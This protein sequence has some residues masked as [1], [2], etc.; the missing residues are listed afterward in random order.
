M[1]VQLP[2]HADVVVVGVGTAGAV[3]AGRLAER[4][5]RDVL[6]LEAGP[7]YGP[8]QRAHWPTELLDAR[9]L[10]ETHD[11][12]YSGGNAIGDP[13]DVLT[14][15]GRRRMLVSQWLFAEHRLER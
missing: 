9:R 14:G 1:S 8:R 3:V 11:W 10:P 15:A 5:D 12:G 13:L 7:D 6:A 4:D 2:A